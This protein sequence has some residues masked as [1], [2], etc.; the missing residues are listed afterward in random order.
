MS[1]ILT[2][3]PEHI[4]KNEYF[5]KTHPIKGVIFYVLYKYNNMYSTCV[6]MYTYI[7]CIFQSIFSSTLYA[8]K[9]T[10]LQTGRSRVLFPMGTIRFFT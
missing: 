5:F 8:N 9:C 10:A 4:N 1:Y 6:C 2:I 7:T 3:A